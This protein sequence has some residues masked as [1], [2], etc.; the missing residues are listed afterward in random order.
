MWDRKKLRFCFLDSEFPSLTRLLV[1]SLIYLAFVSEILVGHCHPEVVNA[2]LKQME[3]LNTNSRFLHDNIV[4]YAKRVTATLPEKLSVC[5]FTNSGYVSR[6]PTR[7]P[8]IS[9]I[10]LSHIPFLSAW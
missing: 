5:Y 4:E 7:L 2:A 3:L 9:L 6:F 1:L 10:T 8:A